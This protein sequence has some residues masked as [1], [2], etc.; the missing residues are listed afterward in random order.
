MVLSILHLSFA[1]KVVLF[2]DDVFV[3]SSATLYTKDKHFASSSYSVKTVANIQKE[4][5]EKGKQRE[6][7]IIA[8][9]VFRLRIRRCCPRCQS[10]FLR[11]V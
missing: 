1:F 3:L 9:G 5:M 10:Y 2:Y 8:T 6:C 7:L 4:I 11:F